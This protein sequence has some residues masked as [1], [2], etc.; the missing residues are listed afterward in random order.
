MSPRAILCNTPSLYI[1]QHTR[2]HALVAESYKAGKV[3]AVLCH[4]TCILLK[5]KLIGRGERKEF[6]HSLDPL[7]PFATVCSW[8]VRIKHALE[9]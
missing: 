1:L 7:R 8:E 4:A 2:V 5:A 9:K 3:T 6:S